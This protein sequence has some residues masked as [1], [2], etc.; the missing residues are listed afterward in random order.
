MKFALYPILLWITLSITNAH[1][2]PNILFIQ[3]DDQAPWALGLAHPE[4]D[5]PHMD[6]LFR[7]SAYLRNTFTVTPVCS[8]LRA[9]LMTS[10]MA[11]NSASPNGSIQGRNLRTDRTALGQYGRICGIRLVIRLDWQVAFGLVRQ[12]SP[13]V[14]RI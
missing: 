10:L 14:I 8:P 13:D 12:I 1:D 4:V 11:Q 2:P 9:S 5:T 3:T 6:R 7:E